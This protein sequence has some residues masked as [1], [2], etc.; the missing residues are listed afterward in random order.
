MK[1][2]KSEK[3]KKLIVTIEI[4]AFVAAAILAVLWALN[5]N[6]NYEPFTLICGL[7][8]TGIE[9]FR[10]FMKPQALADL[11]PTPNSTISEIH[12]WLHNNSN[13]LNLS[14]TLPHA[15]DLAHRINDSEFEH[16]VK[17]ELYGYNEQGGMKESDVVPEYREITGRH[18]D[19]Y[20]RMFTVND[21][22]MDIVNS[23]RL[24]FGVGKLEELSKADDM[25][26][27]RDEGT[28]NIMREHLGVEV[29]RFCFSPVEVV[30]VLN[31]IKLKLMEWIR[32]LKLEE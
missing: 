3:I 14:E 30:G 18:M 22:K 13:R 11:R 28:I 7:V 27:I 9:I 31:N 26:N 24:R 16:W 8:G 29:F 10:R 25:L 6:G 15:L 12:E 17:M 2:I 20:N 5:P 1:K 21:P 32:K 19:A 23:I 4:F